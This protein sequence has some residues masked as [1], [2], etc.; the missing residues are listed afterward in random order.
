MCF[1]RSQTGVVEG[2]IDITSAS[3]GI[4]RGDMRPSS[5]RD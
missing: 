5:R 2:K 1:S 3:G 4:R